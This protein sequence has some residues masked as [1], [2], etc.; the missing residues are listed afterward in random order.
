[1]QTNSIT[2][3]LFYRSP[4]LLCNIIFFVLEGCHMVAPSDMM[5]GRVLAIK[6]ALNSHGFGG[7]VSILA[8]SAKFASKFYG[9]FRFI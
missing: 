6:T 1:M 3:R 4:K 9:P 5:D 7:K 2:H 8:Y